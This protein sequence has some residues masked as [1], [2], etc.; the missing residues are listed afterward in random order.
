MSCHRFRTIGLK[1]PM[2]IGKFAVKPGAP[3]PGLLKYAESGAWPLGLSPPLLET[4]PG[5]LPV[6]RLAAFRYSINLKTA[7]VLG[8]TI[9]DSVLSRAE[10]VIPCAKLRCESKGGAT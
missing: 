7:K 1:S 3:V 10:V 4:A 9:P 2:M 8:M 5:D 6:Q